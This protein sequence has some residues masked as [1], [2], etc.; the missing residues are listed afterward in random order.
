MKILS[1]SQVIVTMSK[2]SYSSS[3]HEQSDKHNDQNI[4]VISDEAIELGSVKPE[5]NI[6]ENTE[7]DQDQ[8]QN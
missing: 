4:T 6:Y 5:E 1:G 8:A 3:K 7:Q 2:E